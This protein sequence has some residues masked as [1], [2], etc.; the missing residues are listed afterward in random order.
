MGLALRGG[1]SMWRLIGGLLVVGAVIFFLEGYAGRGLVLLAPFL[2][3]GAAVVVLYLFFLRKGRLERETRVAAE[4]DERRRLDAYREEKAAKIGPLRDRVLADLAVVEA[5]LARE[6]ERLAAKLAA[7]RAA[8]APPAKIAALEDCARMLEGALQVKHRDD[9][10]LVPQLEIGIY[11]VWPQES[12]GEDWSVRPVYR[13]YESVEGTNSTWPTRDFRSPAEITDLVLGA[14]ADM[15]RTSWPM[16]VDE[17]GLSAYSA[18][19]LPVP[20]VSGAA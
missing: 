17:L 20:A 4:A 6:K 3:F 12:V 16:L 5:S 19:A 2:L 15:V 13:A 7:E 9:I 1:M 8:G 11:R 14:Y 18:R 10:A